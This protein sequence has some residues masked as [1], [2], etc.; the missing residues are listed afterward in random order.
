MN[1]NGIGT[2]FKLANFAEGGTLPSKEGTNALSNPL[3]D[4]DNGYPIGGTFIGQTSTNPGTSF[5]PEYWA[6]Y[7]P[8]FLN[9]SSYNS[10]LGNFYFANYP[11]FD[12]TANFG[13]S[14][15]GG[16]TH[17]DGI[18][19]SGGRVLGLYGAGA[20]FNAFNRNADRTF[21]DPPVTNCTTAGTTV[22]SG[23]SFFSD[24]LWTHHSW[25]Q[26]VA[27][28]DSANNVTFGAFVRCPAN[29]IFR[30][31]NFGGVYV[32]EDTATSSPTNVSIDTIAIR[33]SEVTLTLA[34]GSIASGQGHYQWSGLSDTK[35]GNAYPQRWN[36]T[37]NVRSV[38]YKDAEDFANFKE[39]SKTV[40]I[41][42]TGTGRRMGISL[43]FAEN[44]A[45][46]FTIPDPNARSG[47]IQFYNPFLIFS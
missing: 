38:T 39:V 46:L 19:Y 5:Y 42:A 45:Y 25:N 28:P 44:H 10:F 27:I 24:D 7:S 34:N 4:A 41:R 30:D 16:G 18:N 29:D 40:S 36:D 23:T 6:P 47:L 8:L 1:I 15:A 13:G 33:R 9:T 11:N 22:N 20:N 31:L 43:Y 32:W 3:F 26:G 12:D 35:S 21:P 14:E 37:C 17:L 2:G